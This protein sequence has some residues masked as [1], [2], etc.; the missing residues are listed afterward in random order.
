MHRWCSGRTIGYV[1]PMQPQWTKFGKDQSANSNL[2]KTIMYA[3]ID[4]IAEN[5]DS[6]YI[7]TQDAYMKK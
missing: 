5:Q 2:P 3:S 1:E 6:K 7:V 4:M